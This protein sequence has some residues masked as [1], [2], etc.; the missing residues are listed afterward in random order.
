MLSKVIIIMEKYLGIRTKI[1]K[2]ASMAIM[3]FE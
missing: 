3:Y 2:D 1:D